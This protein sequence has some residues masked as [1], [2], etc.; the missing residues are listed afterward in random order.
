M[1]STSMQSGHTIG[2]VGNGY[3]IK[4]MSLEE[5]QREIEI[6]WYRHLELRNEVYEM[7][8]GPSD[9]LDVYISCQACIRSSI[10]LEDL[11]ELLDS[12]FQYHMKLRN[13]F[14]YLKSDHKNCQQ[15]LHK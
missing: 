11:Q 10:A 6:T 15:E 1:Y 14:Y 8:M 12:N 2:N 3:I 13:Q 4:K 9:I 7:K 5:L